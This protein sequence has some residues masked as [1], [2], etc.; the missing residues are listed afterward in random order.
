MNSRLNR[1]LRDKRGLVY[2]VDSNVALLSDCGIMQIYAGSDIDKAD[3][4]ITLIRRE[5]ERLASDTL[6]RPT[7]DAIVNQ[8]CG[9]LLVG[10]DNRENMAMSMA[11]SL[12]YF[13]EILDM[14]QTTERL[15]AVTPEDIRQIAEMLASA[16]SAA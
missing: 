3:K 11:K 9:Q 13:N 12:I 15:R 6:S 7:F 10:S 8:Y 1:E 16:P 4:C 14:R 5:I 2:T